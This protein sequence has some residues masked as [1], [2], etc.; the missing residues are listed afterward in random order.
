ML[1]NKNKTLLIQY[2]GEKSGAY[3]IPDSVTSIGEWAFAYCDSLTSVAIPD[4]VTTIGDSAFRG[5]HSLTS[6]TIGNG[7]TR[8]G[9]AAFSSC[10]SLTDVYY[11]GSEAQWA[12]ITIGSDN[13]PLT[14]ATIHYNS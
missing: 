1:F 4:S 9:Y 5:C 8:I 11:R 2:P 6:V 7:V 12:A 14:S 13:D 3:T 10:D